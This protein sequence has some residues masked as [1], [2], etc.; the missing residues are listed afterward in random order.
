M[1]RYD[2]PQLTDNGAVCSA[3]V[4][5]S[6]RISSSPT[7]VTM[8][9]RTTRAHQADGAGE[10]RERV[11]P[12]DGPA[13]AAEDERRES[14]PARRDRL[15]WRRPCNA[16]PGFGIDGARGPA[17]RLDLLPNQ[18]V[19]IRF[20]RQRQGSPLELSGHSWSPLGPPR[21]EIVSP[22][23]ETGRDGR[24]CY[25]SSSHSTRCVGSAG[26][27][28]GVRSEKFFGFSAA[29][30]DQRRSVAMLRPGPAPASV[31][32]RYPEFR[33]WECRR[34]EEPGLEPITRFREGRA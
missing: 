33:V 18:P 21:S 12:C 3:A 28:R 7:M 15:R 29:V 8:T 9:S 19:V 10:E 25:R 20:V 23:G 5:Q 22:G 11:P 13:V 16:D 6:R 4:L 30:E 31:D 34:H 17:R 26:V 32:D 2:V 24:C 14:E 27:S 1:T